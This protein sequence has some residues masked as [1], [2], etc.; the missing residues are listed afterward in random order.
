VVK[1]L[2]PYMA[3]LIIGLLIIAFV[4]WI[5]LGFLPKSMLQ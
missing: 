1:P 3:V 2:I 5:S 4:P